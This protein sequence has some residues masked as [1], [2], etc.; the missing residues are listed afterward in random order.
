VGGLLENLSMVVGLKAIALLALAIY[1]GS[2]QAGL[3]R[4][5]PQ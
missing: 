3:R 1:L 2:L 4:P 5:A